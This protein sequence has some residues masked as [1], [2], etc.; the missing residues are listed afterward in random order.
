MTTRPVI[1][2][3]CHNEQ[4]SWNGL[5]RQVPMRRIGDGMYERPSACCECNPRIEM[6]MTE[7]PDLSAELYALPVLRFDDVSTLYP[8]TE[9][10]EGSEPCS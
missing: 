2:V 10:L 1:Y 5:V 9:G 8:V 3:V 7:P 6:K 4:C